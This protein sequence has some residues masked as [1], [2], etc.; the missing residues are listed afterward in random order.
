MPIRPPVHQPVGALSAIERRARYDRTRSSEHGRIYGRRWRALRAAYLASHPLCECG[1]GR[2]AQVVDHIEPHNG[3]E[4]LLYSWNNL[5]A[6]TKACHD[7]KTT[8]LDGGFGNPFRG[9][10]Q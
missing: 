10:R 1:C 9:K 5:Q 2:G 4:R 6:M 8:S 7:A 3:D